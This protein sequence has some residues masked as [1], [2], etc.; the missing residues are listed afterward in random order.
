MT[1]PVSL[2]YGQVKWAAV[3]AHA[4]SAS[5]PDALPDAIPVTGSVTFTPSAR[6]FLIIDD[7]PVT[8]IATDVTYQLGDDGVLRDSQGNDTV[9]LLANDSPYTTPTGWTWIVSYR[10]NNGLARGAFPFKLSAGEIVDLTR[11]SPVS[12]SGGVPI[13][14]GPQGDPG[15]SGSSPDFDDSVD[16]VVVIENAL[17]NSG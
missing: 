17:S 12:A 6:V 15:P 7:N 13:I 9:T 4:D 3:S 5:D 8:V 11:V 10:L 14:Q 1:L 2:R 16:F